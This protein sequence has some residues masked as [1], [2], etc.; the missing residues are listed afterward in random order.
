MKKI[1]PKNCFFALVKDDCPMKNKAVAIVTHKYWDNNG[2]LDDRSIGHKISGLDGFYEEGS[3]YFVPEDESLEGEALRQKL[4]SLGFEE[5]T[6]ILE[7]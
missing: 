5:Y 4:L 7:L 2:C 3:S 6:E 1:A